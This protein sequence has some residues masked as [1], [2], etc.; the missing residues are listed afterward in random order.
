MTPA[1]E[2]SSSGIRGSSGGAGSSAAAS[3]DPP[4]RGATRRAT[5]QREPT[6][7]AEQRA[8][9]RR[10][11]ARGGRARTCARAT[12]P[13]VARAGA[14]HP[15]GGPLRARPRAPR[16]GPE[17]ASIASSFMPGSISCGLKRARCEELGEPPNRGRSP[18]PLEHAP[19]VLAAAPRASA[20][21]PVRG[22]RPL[23]PRVRADH[24][25]PWIALAA[26]VVERLGEHRGDRLGGL[27]HV[28]TGSWRFRRTAKTAIALPIP[29]TNE[30]TDE[31]HPAE[32]RLVRVGARLHRL[33]LRVW[34]CAGSLARRVVPERRSAPDLADRDDGEDGHDHDRH[35]GED[36]H[37]RR[38]HRRLRSSELLT[39]SVERTPYTSANS[40]IVTAPRIAPTTS[41]ATTSPDTGTEP[42]ARTAAAAPALARGAGPPAPGPRQAPQPSSAV[43]RP[44]LPAFR[45]AS[46]STP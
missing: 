4:S 14:E 18:E 45:H 1:L 7:A 9:R 23:H 3:R 38:G 37:R 19:E 5:D 44:L 36:A 8:R 17:S 30:P 2:R 31:Q 16:A 40:T 6:P 43:L 46:P 12:N 15:A 32:L 26:Q 41:I 34:R 21:Q 42:S 35:R 22:E 11:R 28:A 29:T 24:R 39:C 13:S 20:R 25:L 33:L 10:A 27:R